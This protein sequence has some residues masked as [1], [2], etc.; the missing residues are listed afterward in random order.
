MGSLRILIAYLGYCKSN[1]PTAAERAMREK[2]ESRIAAAL[3]GSF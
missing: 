2:R 1:E 3:S